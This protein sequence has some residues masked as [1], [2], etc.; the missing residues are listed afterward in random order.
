MKNYKITIQYDGTRYNGWQRQ[1][2]TKNTLQERFESVLS[3]MAG[4]NVEVFASG[5]TDAGVHALAQVA[6][7]KC[8]TPLSPDEIKGYLNHYLPED[9]AVT[10]IEEK[11]ERF[12]SRLSAK[13]KTYEYRIALSKPDVFKRKYVFF[14]PGNV[15]VSAMKQA[16]EYLVGKH[17]FKG[18]SST[19]TKKSTERTIYSLDVSLDENLLTIRING[20]G[21]LYN[22]VRI[23]AGTLLS[24]GRGERSPESVCEVFATN[25]RALAGPTLPACGL[26]LVEVIY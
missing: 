2:N 26:T 9:V 21:F 22:M 13:S 5:R 18:Y 15:D 16:A 7:F 14:S 23:L 25:N 17:D 10:E 1:G 11:N 3:K 12:H 20:S 24:V 6:N 4:H 19:K 8:E